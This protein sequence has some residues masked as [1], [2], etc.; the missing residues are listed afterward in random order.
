MSAAR[1]WIGEAV[2]THGEGMADGRI[3]VPRSQAALADEAGC[4]AGTIAYYLRVL[5]DAVSTSRREGLIVDPRLLGLDGGSDELARRRRRS[6]EVADVLATTWGQIPDSWDRMELADDNGRAPTVREMAVVLGLNPSTTQRHLENLSR[7]GRLE[8]HG[9]HLYLH[10]AE[11]V[12]RRR[13]AGGHADTDEPAQAGSTQELEVL[14]L[15]AETAAALIRVAE[16]LANLGRGVLDLVGRPTANQTRASEGDPRPARALIAANRE[17]APTFAATVPS[18]SVR[19]VYRSFLPTSELPRTEARNREPAGD[20]RG[21]EPAEPARITARTSDSEVAQALIPLQE[22]CERLSLPSAI[23]DKGY[24]WLSVLSREELDRGVTQV[25]RQ[26]R[27]GARIGA[28]M[29]LLVAKAKKGDHTFFAPP[30]QRSSPGLDDERAVGVVEEE[31]PEA[32]A[33]IAAMSPAE[34][35]RLDDAVRDRLMVVFGP[36]SRSIAG[37][38]DTQEGLAHWRSTIWREQQLP[39]EG[40]V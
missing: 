37:V 26:L 32:K 21:T 1:A 24:R 38:L 29:G 6:A 22:A 36:R 30:P 9:R 15:L 13:P 27:S 2:D 8:R 12:R 20:S 25:L 19:E 35:D 11:T 3:R 14:A 33:A 23:D 39:A 5:G 40:A 28:P 7:E 10:A 18:Q 34:L 31:D 4:S 16:D 17:C